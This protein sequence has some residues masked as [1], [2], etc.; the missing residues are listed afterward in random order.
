MFGD[1][2]YDP[3]KLK[4]LVQEV[5]IKKIIKNPNYGKKEYICF[6]SNKAE[7]AL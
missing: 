1:K 4:T 5:T 2:I 6:M 7:Q 3:S